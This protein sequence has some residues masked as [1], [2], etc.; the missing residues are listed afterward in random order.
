MSVAIWPLFVRAATA[1]FLSPCFAL[2]GQPES[3]PPDYS[4]PLFT[5]RNTPVCESRDD[6]QTLLSLLRSGQKDLLNQVQ[7]CTFFP[8]DGVPVVVLDREGILDVWMRVRLMKPYGDQRTVW[9]VGWMLRNDDSPA[10]SG[11]PAL[12]KVRICVTN[13]FKED[14]HV[15][16]LAMFKN[17]GVLVGDLQD[18]WAQD[19]YKPDTVNDHAAL[20]S[21]EAADLTAQQPCEQVSARMF[22][23][24]GYTV[25]TWQA[26]SD[27]VWDFEQVLG[28]TVGTL[29]Q[30][31]KLNLLRGRIG[32]RAVVTA[33]IGNPLS[34]SE[35]EAAKSEPE[36]PLNRIPLDSQ[37]AH[38]APA[39]GPD[40]KGNF[41][42]CLRRDI[43]SVPDKEAYVVSV[44][45][46]VI[47]ESAGRLIGDLRDP[48]PDTQYALY[49]N[50][51][52][53]AVITLTTLTLSKR[54]PCAV[55]S[56]RSVL[57]SSWPWLFPLVR[58]SDHLHF[59]ALKLKGRDNTNGLPGHLGD[60]LDAGALNG[61]PTADIGRPLELGDNSP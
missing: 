52:S 26:S 34:T 53:W 44:P 18:D 35:E 6:L 42:V 8:M 23:R 43:D 12:G 28:Y 49:D 46:N 22:V 5:Q 21:T 54:K 60:A 7:G 32:L 29:P 9:T 41:K 27:H 37:L 19:R 33:D 16:A 3:T 48:D 50:K 14:T 39:N 31:G 17:A 36:N 45:P 10:I 25:K 20:V 11:D 51:T 1:V 38:A 58:E 13:G 40:G 30:P 24:D 47:F 4:K 55:I 56:V 15:P 59:Q 2:A 57:S 61:T